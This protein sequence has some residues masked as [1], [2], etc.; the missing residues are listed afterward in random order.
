MLNE[1]DELLL[2]ALAGS[3]GSDGKLEADIAV[4]WIVV[5]IGEINLDYV[6][7]IKERADKGFMICNI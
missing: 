7:C 5:V 2:E 4:S 3:R 6:L 1:E